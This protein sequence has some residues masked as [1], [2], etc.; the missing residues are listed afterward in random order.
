MGRRK[1]RDISGWLVLDKPAGPSSNTLV[2]KVRWA[3]DA[4][5]AGHAGTLDPELDQ[6]MVEH[7]SWF[8]HGPWL[9]L[10]GKLSYIA[11]VTYDANKTKLGAPP[12]GTAAYEGL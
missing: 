12:K 10:F 3:F 5:K 2:N 1:G 9:R 7:G 8:A 4:K 6:I 11:S